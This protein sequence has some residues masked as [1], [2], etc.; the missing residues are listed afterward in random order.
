[1]SAFTAMTVPGLAASTSVESFSALRLNTPAA[2]EVASG[3]AHGHTPTR[4]LRIEEQRRRMTAQPRAAHSTQQ[5]VTR[6]SSCTPR[7]R[8][9][10]RR[11]RR[12][13]RLRPLRPSRAQPRRRRRPCASAAWPGAR[14]SGGATREAYVGAVRCTARRGSKYGAQPSAALL[15]RMPAWL[16]R[17][18][19]GP[20]AASTRCRLAGGTRSWLPGCAACRARAPSRGAAPSTCRP[21]RARCTS[22][23]WARCSCR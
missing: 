4:R 2:R 11:K 3:R 15:L 18:R 22:T 5:L 1:M 7:W 20:S 8:R 9:R 17:S 14:R 6:L 10:R 19:R 21:L 23:A 12:R 13:E 16:A